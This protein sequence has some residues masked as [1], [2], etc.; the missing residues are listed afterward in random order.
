MGMT[1]LSIIL[2]VFVL[3]LYHVTPQQSPVPDW[4]RTCMFGCIASALHMR[5][6]VDGFRCTYVVTSQDDCSDSG[7]ARSQPCRLSR[8]QNAAV[9][10]D[11]EDRKFLPQKCNI[12]QNGIVTSSA[13][14]GTRQ[15]VHAVETE[16]TAASVK[17]HR[18]HVHPRGKNQL[19]C[20]QTSVSVERA[21][22]IVVERSLHSSGG[23]A[24]DADLD[25]QLRRTIV[26]EW[27]LVAFVMD[28]LLFVLFLIIST[29]STIAILVILPLTKPSMID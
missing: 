11:D 3:Q 14:A 27:K 29:L 21:L 24:S 7:S 4:L 10:D 9:D 15:Q 22:K 20:R 1:S 19:S 5:E 18:H 26:N 13:S 8:I 23:G 12:G 28:R 17:T 25:E 6:T 16:A 2:T